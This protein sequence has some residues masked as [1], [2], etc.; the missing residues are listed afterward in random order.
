MEI[1]LGSAKID[2]VKQRTYVKA[3]LLE[4]IT[5]CHKL[6]PHVDY[7]MSAPATLPDP[8]ISIF[9]PEQIYERTKNEKDDTILP[10]SPE[11][12]LTLIEDVGFPNRFF[13]GELLYRRYAAYYMT[14]N[15]PCWLLREKNFSASTLYWEEDNLTL[16]IVILR[17]ALTGP[18]KEVI[19]KRCAAMRRYWQHPLLFIRKLKHSKHNAPDIENILN[20]QTA[21]AGDLYEKFSEADAR[22]QAFITN[23]QIR[24]AQRDTELSL[25]LARTSAENSFGRQARFCINEDH[26]RTYD[27][28][29]TSNIYSDYPEYS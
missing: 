17:K 16:T 13:M 25:K 23:L 28:I 12:V 11:D 8:G 22:F 10:I 27:F 24:V 4:R 2:I 29:L 26:S 6:A 9:T 5:G 21:L 15:G 3:Y 19:I 7:T 14:P 20:Y 1:L 18:N